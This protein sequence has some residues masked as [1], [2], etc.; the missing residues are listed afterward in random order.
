MKQKI[1]K[2]I[3][4]KYDHYE[5]KNCLWVKI[6]GE[7]GEIYSHRIWLG[8]VLFSI[9]YYSPSE[10]SAQIQILIKKFFRTYGSKIQY[11]LSFFDNMGNCVV[12]SDNN[13]VL[14]D[15]V[16]AEN[17]WWPLEKQ[18]VSGEP[19]RLQFVKEMINFIQQGFYTQNIGI[20]YPKMSSTTMKCHIML[21]VPYLS[22]SSYFDVYLNFSV[23]RCCVNAVEFS[24]NFV[25]RFSH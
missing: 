2:L 6:F 25:Q 1:I 5:P 23:T 3:N 11:G 14:I 10:K 17:V 15:N 4:L 12:D 18:Q 21:L 8:A 20:M 9:I 24:Q 19:I 22:T 13:L 7:I 16:N